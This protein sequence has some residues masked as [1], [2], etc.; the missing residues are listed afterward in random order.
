M[1]RRIVLLSEVQEAGKRKAAVSTDILRSKA[2]IQCVEVLE[3]ENKIA[4]DAEEIQNAAQELERLAETAKK[5]EVDMNDIDGELIQ[6]SAEL[7]ASDVGIKQDQLKELVKLQQMYAADSEQWRKITNEL[8]KWEEDE[9][10]TDYVSNPMLNRIALFCKGKVDEELCQNLRKNILDAKKGID[11]ILRST[12]N[13]GGI[14]KE[15]FES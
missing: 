2:M 4:A 12:M 9:I 10:V 11:E 6:V 7:K 8:R 3:L 15:K 13:S 5:I 1:R 14:W